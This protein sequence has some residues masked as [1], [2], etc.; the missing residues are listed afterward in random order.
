MKKENFYKAQDIISDVDYFDEVLRVAEKESVNFKIII[1]HVGSTK[2]DMSTSFRC[3]GGTGTEF[4]KEILAVIKKKAKERK[5]K[6]EE[7]LAKL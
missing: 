5:K 2:F 1:E 6:L 7:E 3:G 4:Q